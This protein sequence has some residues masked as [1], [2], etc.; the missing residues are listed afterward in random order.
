MDTDQPDEQTDFLI[1]FM[2]NH[3]KMA[4]AQIT[5][6]GPRGQ[7][8]Y[9]RIWELLSSYLNTLGEP[10]TVEGWKKVVITLHITFKFSTIAF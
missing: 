8:I 10:K 6:L 2:E 1:C 7:E 4:K 9:N 3:T 5:S